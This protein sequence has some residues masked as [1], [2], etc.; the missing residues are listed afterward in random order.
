MTDK[1]LQSWLLRQC[2][3]LPGSRRA[4][5]LTGSP[6]EGPYN[7]AIYWPDDQGDIP[8]LKRM[9]EAVLRSNQ[10]VIKTRNDTTENT[11][12]PL[13]AM[14]CPILSQGQL[15]GIVVIEMTTRSK[16]MQQAAI[17]QVQIGLKWLETMSQMSTSVTKEQ[18]VT[19]I[20]LIVAGMEHENFQ[21][22]L[23]HVATELAERFSCQRVSIGFLHYNRLRIEASSHSQ[24]IDRQSNLGRSIRDAMTE[25]VDQEISVIYP[26]END[27]AIQLTHF[28]EK[29]CKQQEGTAICTVP[30]IKDATVVG[31]LL[32][33]REMKE[34]FT[35]ETI[36]QCEQISLLLGPVLETRRRD[37]RFLGFKVIDS[38]RSGI[39]KL[40]G[41]KH[42]PLKVVSTFSVFILLWL[43]LANS[44]FS[45]ATDSV[46]EACVCRVIVAPQEGYIATAHAR[47]GDLVQ[48]GD[49]LAT[50]D[51]KKL[52]QE[53]RKWQSQREQI[54]KEYRQAL[55]SADRAEVSI[56][57]AK[58]M[59]AEAQLQ[60]V[61]QQLERTSL[62]APFSGLVVKGDLSQTLGSPVERG[63]ILYEVAPTGE[64]KVILKVAERDIG[65][66]A[67]GQKGKLRLSGSSDQLIDI[68]I[69]RVTPVSSVEEGL[70]YFRVE[71][72]MANHSD[73]LRP[74]MEGVTRIEIGQAKRLW[75][76]TRRM[77]EW[78]RL[79]TWNWLP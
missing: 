59:Q 25:A 30:L 69:E 5:L 31:A 36:E 47:A 65:L 50:L 20:D 46:L 26:P 39:G 29:L 41:R 21:V 22:A 2:Q 18:C 62:I 45:I 58:Q 19:L 28:H 8:S 10:S 40:F 38:F 52:R 15:I 74:G 42:L 71:A 48:E 61:E 43:S 56:L 60:L 16:P 78:W 79:F 55:A 33:E 27:D 24:L 49:L 54:I 72:L 6:N 76:W 23:N 1:I 14:A 51:D 7:C 4:V 70:N 12:E 13:D 3:I 44:Q 17:Q 77:V 34:P 67:T 75:I 68:Q 37:E 73:L 9:T 57:N 64:Y 53:R 66:I 35:S 32:L 11:G 63:E